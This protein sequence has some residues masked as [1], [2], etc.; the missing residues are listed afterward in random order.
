MSTV[1]VMPGL[2][3]DREGDYFGIGIK[4]DETGEIAVRAMTPQEASKLMA[5]LRSLLYGPGEVEIESLDDLFP[6]LD[7]DDDYPF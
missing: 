7:W 5:M 3:L 1:Y 6:Y 2:V 4:D